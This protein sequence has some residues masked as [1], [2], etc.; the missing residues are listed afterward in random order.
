MLLCGG[1]QGQVSRERGQLMFIPGLIRV[2][3]DPA[4]GVL[5]PLGCLLAF[6]RDLG[7]RLLN[8]GVSDATQNHIQEEEK[9][10][11]FHPPGLV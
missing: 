7:G 3:Q 9:H 11:P 2:M 10:L 1:F 4:D 6:L 8:A 5:V